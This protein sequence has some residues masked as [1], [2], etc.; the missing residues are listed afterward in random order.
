[1][2][3]MHRMW[4]HVSTCAK[5]D[6]L[7]IERVL[8]RRWLHGAAEVY[9]IDCDAVDGCACS[10][11]VVHTRDGPA[12]PHLR[13][14]K[15][16]P[17]LVC[18]VRGTTCALLESYTASSTVLTCFLSAYPAPHGS[19]NAPPHASK[20]HIVQSMPTHKTNFDQ[21]SRHTIT[22][23]P[24]I[25]STKDNQHTIPAQSTAADVVA[26]L[27]LQTPTSA[28]HDARLDTQ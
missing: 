21:Q 25:S 27:Q 16:S 5:M 17:H 15:R 28:S 1:M 8:P 19:N 26:L 23:T 18:V 9:V 11:Y 12:S 22:P 3:R 7:Q 14:P 10:N 2:H 13:V 20:K 4:S 6:A 24:R